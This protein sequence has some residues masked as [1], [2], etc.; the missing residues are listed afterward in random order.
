MIE[1]FVVEFF[2][3]IYDGF[4]DLIIVIKETSSYLF[5]AIGIRANS[6]IFKAVNILFGY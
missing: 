3:L 2:E 6:F 4:Y 5:L 1:M